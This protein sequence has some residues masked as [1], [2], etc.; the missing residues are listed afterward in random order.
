LST[1]WSGR[2]ASQVEPAG[3]QHFSGRIR[4]AIP[5][6]TECARLHVSESASRLD[7]AKSPAPESDVERAPHPPFA[8]S[9][10]ARARAAAHRILESDA[11]GQYLVAIGGFTIVASTGRTK[12][13][14]R[15]LL[16]EVGNGPFEAAVRTSHL[17]G[18]ALPMNKPVVVLARVAKAA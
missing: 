11:C 16:G 5:E 13:F 7:D 2:S 1:A 6:A 4:C 3:L 14:E 12:L 15:R 8:R 9:A 10:G 18:Y 17:P